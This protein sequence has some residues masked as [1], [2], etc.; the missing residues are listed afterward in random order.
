MASS[1]LR[2]RSK[3]KVDGIH[4]TQG[5]CLHFLHQDSTS[6]CFPQHHLQRF[7]FQRLFPDLDFSAG[8]FVAPTLTSSASSHS[9]GSYAADFQQYVTE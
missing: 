6:C 9:N 7:L 5:I 3:F 2:S 1:V 4:D 8:Q